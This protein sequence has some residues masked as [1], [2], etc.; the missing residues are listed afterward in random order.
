M[1]NGTLI[2]S[3][4]VKKNLKNSLQNSIFNQFIVKWSTKPYLNNILDCK[5]F[6]AATSFNP[7][8]AINLFIKLM[9]LLGSTP[10]LT[11]YFK[12]FATTNLY[13]LRR[14]GL[15]KKCGKN[16]LYILDFV[17]ITS[18]YWKLLIFE[19]NLMKIFVFAL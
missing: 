5:I 18:Y 4:N 19:N 10:G 14:R 16:N 9:F 17:F 8:R 11:H 13:K 6:I 3:K 1:K 2:K 7:S 15:I 12:L